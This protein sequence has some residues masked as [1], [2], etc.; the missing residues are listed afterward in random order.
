MLVGFRFAQPFMINS[1]LEFIGDESM[2]QSIGNGL[3]GA[4]ALVYAG[5]AVSCPV[6]PLSESRLT[7]VRSPAR[8]ID[9]TCTASSSPSTAVSFPSSTSTRPVHAQS[10]LAR[11]TA[12][13]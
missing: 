1:V 11:L 7:R 13:R 3:I 5:M 10:I 12:S 4:Y 6:Y 9:T 8:C 2:P